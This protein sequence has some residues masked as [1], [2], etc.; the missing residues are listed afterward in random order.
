MCSL[1]GAQKGERRLLDWSTTLTTVSSD[2][3]LSDT[4]KKKSGERS[5]AGTYL[6]C[7]ERR[8]REQL[9]AMKVACSAGLLGT[10]SD[11]STLQVEIGSGITQQRG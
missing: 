11:A 4:R 3:S 6:C 10:T 5:C 7:G 1:S 8:E 9:F 2:S